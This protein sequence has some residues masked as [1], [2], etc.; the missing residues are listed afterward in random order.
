MKPN[1]IIGVTCIALA[2]ILWLA[3]R[4]AVVLPSPSPTPAPGPRNVFLLEQDAE[5]NQHPEF[6]DLIGDP[7]VLEYMEAQG[8]T[9]RVID[10]ESAGVYAPLF[11][12]AQALPWC[13][14]GT[15]DTLLYS[16]PPPATAADLI[17]LTQ[18]HGG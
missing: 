14:I 16:G 7:S 15:G 8:H 17:A 6:R 13:M 5:R 18:K 2:G 10:K 4:G 11:D 9:Y 12:G 1:Q 3:D